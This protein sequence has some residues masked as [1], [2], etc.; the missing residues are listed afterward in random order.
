MITNARRRVSERVDARASP[1]R[2]RL[3]PLPC[4]SQPSARVWT[5]IRYFRLNSIIVQFEIF[6]FEHTNPRCGGP[7]SMTP[8]AVRFICYTSTSASLSLPSLPVVVPRLTPPR[9]RRRGASG[10]VYASHG[11]VT[12]LHVPLP[13]A[14]HLVDTPSHRQRQNLLLGFFILQHSGRL[15]VGARDTRRRGIRRGFPIDPSF[16]TLRV[17]CQPIFCVDELFDTIRSNTT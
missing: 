11:D 2:E 1:R 10:V 4:S 16:E 9:L 5:S 15:G 12:A 6:V 17:G 13:L 14:S 3:R 7:A 8:I